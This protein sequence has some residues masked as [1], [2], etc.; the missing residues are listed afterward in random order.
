MKKHQL[1]W[2]SFSIQC[3]D[4]IYEFIFNETFSE[5]LAQKEVNKLISRVDQLALLPDSGQIELLLK[6]IGQNSRYLVEGSYKIIYQHDEKTV[7][8]TDVFHTSQNPKKIISR[9]KK[10]KF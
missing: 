1:V 6:K 4:E 10:K 3:L 7:I 9:S 8:I 5:T 2:T